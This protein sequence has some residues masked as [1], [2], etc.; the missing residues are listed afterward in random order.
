M[1]NIARE[2]RSDI[3]KCEADAIRRELRNFRDDELAAANERIEALTMRI[4]DNLGEYDESLADVNEQLAAAQ[5][6]RDE[7]VRK[8]EWMEE[9]YAMRHQQLRD[10][11]RSSNLWHAYH[12]IMANGSEGGQPP[13]YAQQ[14]NIMRHRAERAE[15]RIAELEAR[16]P[17]PDVARALPEGWVRKEWKNRVSYDHGDKLVTVYHDGTVRCSTDVRAETLHAIL[18][19]HLSLTAP[20]SPPSAP[21][22]SDCG[23]PGGEHEQRGWCSDDPPPEQQREP[24]VPA[25]EPT[26]ALALLA[27]C[28]KYAREDEM[29]TRHSTRLARALAEAERLLAQQREPQVP[30]TAPESDGEVK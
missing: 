14:F 16:A 2:V 29:T 28:V 27:R 7:S 3:I 21:S 13:T 1:R 30:A 18:A 22:C 9:W 24:Q 12:E 5:A 26:A 8:R 10:T 19:Y 20:A 15:E 6:E 11:L 23:A 4:A 25:T 17:A